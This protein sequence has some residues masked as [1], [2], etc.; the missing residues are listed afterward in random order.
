MNTED[1]S[2]E[3]KE[4]PPEIPVGSRVGA[5]IDARPDGKVRFLGYGTY[6]GDEV[7]PVDIFPKGAPNPKIQLDNGKVVWGCECFW[8]EEERLKEYL[9]KKTIQEVDVDAIREES[10]NLEFPTPPEKAKHGL[11][12]FDKSKVFDEEVEP[13]LKGIH[14][15]CEKHGMNMAAT[16]H[17]STNAEK[18]GRCSVVY[19]G[20]N[21]PPTE[22][23]LAAM[24]VKG[25]VATMMVEGTD[26]DDAEDE[27][28]TL[29]H[30]GR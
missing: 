24:M 6:V 12:E 28:P 20:A 25:E 21:R 19:I 30:P 7:P 2:H 5:F 4:R 26:D 8:G 1:S 3:H 13:L 23:L 18:Y 27:G 10:K 14:A 16:I 9:S 22:F 15:L 17:F 11:P 29:S